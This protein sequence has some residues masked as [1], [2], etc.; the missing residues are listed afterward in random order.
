MIKIENIKWGR[1]SN[2]LLHYNF[3]RQISHTSNVE[4]ICDNDWEGNQYFKVDDTDLTKQL[5]RPVVLTDNDVLKFEKQE[6]LEYIK[7]HDILLQPPLMGELFHTYTDTDPNEFL[8]LK[9]EYKTELKQD[10]YN[11]GIHFRG[12]DFHEWNIK[13]CLPFT[14]YRNAINLFDKKITRFILFTDDIMYSSFWKTKKFLQ[15]N[16]YDYELGISTQSDMQQE[17]KSFIYDFSQLSNCDCIISTPSTF[18]IWGG[19]LGKKDKRII[20][21]KEWLDYRQEEKDPFWINMRNNVNKYY[22]ITDEV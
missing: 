21:S 9:D 2:R 4:F 15:E 18:S 17:G 7:D 13:A 5:D 1:F 6:F 3:L 22:I 19:I 8:E 16:N 14:Y 11:V 10:K 12:T 20:H